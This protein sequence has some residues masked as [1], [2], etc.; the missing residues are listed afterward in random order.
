MREERAH[1]L[2]SMLEDEMDAGNARKRLLCVAEMLRALTDSEHA[3][4]N[5][6]IRAVLAA[7]FGPDCAPAENTINEDIRAIR[8]SGCLGLRVHTGPS[9]TWCEN[10]RLSPA[11]VRLMLNAVQASRFLTQQQSCELQ[12]GLFGLVSRYQEDDLVGE[13]LVDQRVLQGYQEVFDTCDI[14]AQALKTDRKVEF[15]YAYS[16][17][18]GKPVALPGDDGSIVRIETPIALLFS[19]DNYYLESYSEPAWR[20]GFNLTR[21]R[22]DR[23]YDVRVSSEKALHTREVYNAKRSAGK[24]L[25]EGFQMLFGKSRALFLRV[26]AD[27]TNEMF[28]RFGF[29]LSFG[30]F[31]G[32]VGS[33]DTT[34]VTFVRIAQ[35][36]TFYRWLMGM[37]GGVI[38]QRPNS[39]MWVRS[40]P[41]S[42]RVKDIS[43]SQL[44]EDYQ[45]VSS[46]YRAYVET[47]LRSID[48]A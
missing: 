7:K 15:K 6:E 26:R 38:L 19:G 33:V 39:D 43:F 23:M 17:F 34:G 47:A 3:L 48:D 40:G 42:K 1:D 27:K 14:I 32:E 41:W 29:G 20:H 11:N 2:A 35:T 31:D 8:E 13:V 44:V 21:S 30:D 25:R 45:E 37:Q 18:A 4:S 36:P 16:D 5:A 12:E 24:R 22:V 9:G 28:D 10:E 46:G